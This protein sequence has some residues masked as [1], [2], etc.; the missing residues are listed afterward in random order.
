MMIIS[1]FMGYKIEYLNA[2]WIF[3]D[4][5]QPV[6]TT[7][8]QKECGFCGKVRTVEGHDDCLEALPFIMNACCGH[9]NKREAYIQFK[10]GYCISGYPAIA[11]SRLLKCLYQ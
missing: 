8:E 6:E 5:K 10:N 1:K 9:G 7:W 4:T 11:I 2:T 3:C